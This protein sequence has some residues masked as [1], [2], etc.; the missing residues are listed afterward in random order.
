MRT[1]LQLQ[2]PT[3]TLIQG[4]P[5]SAKWFSLP[6]NMPFA[7]MVYCYRGIAESKPHAMGEMKKLFLRTV[8][9][10]PI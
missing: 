9:E 6:H 8:Q 7:A 4:V 3:F 5:F 10:K 1:A 2:G